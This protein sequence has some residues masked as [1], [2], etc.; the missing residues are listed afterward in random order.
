[1]EALEDTEDDD[2]WDDEELEVVTDEPAETGAN[3]GDDE[4]AEEQEED[5]DKREDEEDDDRWMKSPA[6]LSG[7]YETS[8]QQYTSHRVWKCTGESSSKPRQF[9]RSKKA[10][11]FSPKHAKE[12]L[13]QTASSIFTME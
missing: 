12:G 6:A 9:R 13:Q 10:C 4:S 5:D 2:G 8:S 1:M 7:T 11:I 3:L